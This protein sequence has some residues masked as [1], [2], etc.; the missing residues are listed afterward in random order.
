[1]TR[2]VHVSDCFLPRLGGIERHVHDLA[3]RQRQRG[4]RVT[5]LTSVTPDPATA[6]RIEVVGPRGAARRRSGRIAYRR[7]TA[8]AHQLAA[9]G[10]DVVHVHLSGVSPLG[11]LALRA[12][13]VTDTPVVV[14]VHSVLGPAEAAV[15][16]VFAVGSGTRASVAW[17]AVSSAA[18]ASVRRLVGTETPITV[19]PN[20]V[21]TRWWR[22][23][24]DTIPAEV[25]AG[26][27]TLITVGRL[28]RRKRTDRLLAMVR[29][30][31][32]LIGSASRLHTVVIGDG[33]MRRSLERTLRRTDSADAVT[34]LGA[35]DPDRIRSVLAGSD[36]Y[37]APAVLESF[38]I[39]ALEAR[40]AGLPVICFASS[41]ITDFITH[42]KDG[43]LVHDDDG[44]ARAIASL[45]VDP[46]LLRR[47]QHH[48]RSIP[49][50]IQWQDALAGAD[51][52]Y[53]RVLTVRIRPAE[54]LPARA[55]Q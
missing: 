43:L 30:A 50:T 22:S 45:A 28:S 26:R 42:G 4:D 9:L 20:C 54:P 47:L 31:Q 44:M 32:T 11:L 6:A 23:G 21:D 7:S 35:A 2:I 46:A 3:V 37:V 8:T 52:L 33:P 49:P 55:P 16:R 51:A 29:R 5:V 13:V 39:A 1:M 40:S 48:S 18:V 41:G 38:G 14:T 25:R 10:P 27:L 19:V 12:C 17:S 24:D 15:G 34:L 36:V 53:A